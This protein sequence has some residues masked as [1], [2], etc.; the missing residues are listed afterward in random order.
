MKLFR[1]LFS[2]KP[3]AKSARAERPDST[4]EQQSPEQLLNTALTHNSD[5]VKEAAVARLEF[6]DA[7]LELALHQSGRV[8][9]AARKRIGQ[10]L[11]EGL[12]T[13]E[14]L[15]SKLDTDETLLPLISYAPQAQQQYLA[16]VND[17]QTLLTLASE[18]ASS[19]LR[20]SAATRLETRPELEQLCKRVQGR[21]KNVYRM[22]KTKL[23][24]F[25]AEDARIALVHQQIEALCDKLEK[26][27]RQEADSLYKARVDH[28]ESEWL[29]LAGEASPSL[30]ERYQQALAGCQ[31]QID[32][33]AGSIAREEEEQARQ[34]QAEAALRH[35]HAEALQLVGELETLPALDDDQHSRYRDQLEQLQQTARQSSGQGGDAAG[36]R[37]TV[38]RA[39]HYAQH[40]LE[41]FSRSGTL[42]Q[43]K[44]SLQSTGDTL[45][46]ELRQQLT[47]ITSAAQEFH[48]QTLPAIV[49]DINEQLRSLRQR[50]QE[51]SRQLKD[52]IRHLEDLIRR[53]LR[54]AEQGMVRK[55]RGVHKEVQEKAARLGTLPGAVTSKLEDLDAAIARLADWHEFAV[56]PKKEELI[57]QMQALAD[58]PLPP[59]DLATRIHE[60]QDE[61]RSLSKG[62][63]QADESLWEQFQQASQVAFAPCKEYFDAQTREREANLGK[64]REL[65]TTMQTYLEQYDWDKAV[66]KDVEQTLK[67]ARQEWQGY[68]PVPRKAAEALQESFDQVMNQV[69]DK[70]KHF[71]QANKAQKQALIAEAGTLTAHEDLQQAIE[72]IKQLQARWKTIGKSYPREDQQLWSHF[73][74]H[75]DAV[76]ARRADIHNEQQ[77][78]RN[79]QAQQAQALIDELNALAGLDYAALREAQGRVEAIREAFK[80]LSDLPRDQHKAITQSFYQAADLFRDRLRAGKNQAEIQ[81]WQDLFALANDLLAYENSLLKKQ[82]DEALARALTETLASEPVLPAG[83][84]P[85]LQ[86]RFAAAPGLSEQQRND[87]L[88]QLRLIA[89]RAEIVS[90]LPSPETDR[91][92]RMNYQMEQLQ[93]AFGQQEASLE[94]LIFEWVS[95]G[96]IPGDD[97]ERLFVRFME[98]LAKGESA[99]V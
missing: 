42:V 21:D 43:L 14:Q 28:L 47:N 46:A 91:E 71:Y 72:G 8:Q 55:A 74:Q 12:L 29:P 87:N 44:E 25:K 67:V 3:A 7:L 86:Q 98:C 10:Q 51:Q 95:L 96:G 64:R 24:V 48:Q 90:G 82:P 65:V 9:A 97:Y 37:A 16:G 76:F 6:G 78:W 69:H 58:S 63:Q 73:R 70:L 30:Q 53:G 99:S 18:G 32:L 19:Q 5:Q 15:R 20:Q 88:A 68:W 36:L 41:Q 93:Q 31:Q 54:A 92:H 40:L 77:A 83:T 11:E 84:L 4:L 13:L 17:P 61:W 23:D 1:R 45:P 79:Q 60:L 39:R 33:R 94:Q 49:S 22:A 62:V 27:G 75:C 66:W 80:A 89:I 26:M 52:T 57:R 2:A 85:L 56:T 59:E 35:A 34:Q 38:E 50:E 81:S